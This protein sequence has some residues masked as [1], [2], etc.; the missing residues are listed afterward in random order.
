MTAILTRMPAPAPALI[1]V[2]GA[3]EPTEA[4][5]EMARQVGRLV[6][7]AGCGVV[8]GGLGGVME[9]AAQGVSESGGTVIGL[10]PGESP[11]E[12]NPYV[13]VALATGLGELRNGLIARVAAGMIAIG[14]GYGTLSEIAL[15]L[16]LGKPVVGLDTWGLERPEGVADDGIRHAESPELAVSLLLAELQAD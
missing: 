5:R 4:Q 11:D 12:A 3:S 8:C 6:A 10:L 1:A 16:R 14:G 7:A 13:S 15:M 9:A 2:C